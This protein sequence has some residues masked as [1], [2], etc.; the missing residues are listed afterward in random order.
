MCF[1]GNR[2]VN[3][4][5]HG[6][7]QVKRKATFGSEYFPCGLSVTYLGYCL[8]ENY[9]S[10]GLPEMADR[11]DRTVYESQEPSETSQEAG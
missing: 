9:S 7:A 10:E 5:F 4:H 8:R 11:A 6:N 1:C 2:F 3:A